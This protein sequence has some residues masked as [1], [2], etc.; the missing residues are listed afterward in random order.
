MNESITQ[1]S[2]SD[3]WDTL[4]YIVATMLCSLEKREYPCTPCQ[5]NDA[6]SCAWTNPDGSVAGYVKG[7]GIEF[8]ALFEASAF[9]SALSKVFSK[10]FHTK[11]ITFGMRGAK[12]MLTISDSIET[13]RTEAMEKC[14]AVWMNVVDIQGRA[15]RLQFA[16]ES[17]ADLYT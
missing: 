15:E 5:L 7:I 2:R 12:T 6:F 1:V 4:C 9:S 16:I 3:S 13:L 14:E 11:H 8:V 10:L 17:L